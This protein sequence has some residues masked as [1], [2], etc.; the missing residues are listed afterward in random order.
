MAV[1]SIS[2]DT[3]QFSSF[4]VTA[5][6]T[7][8]L[9]DAGYAVTRARTG[10]IVFAARTEEACSAWLRDEDYDPERFAIARGP[11]MNDDAAELDRL[12]AIKLQALTLLGSASW[13]MFR[14]DWFTA[15]WAKSEAEDLA[16]LTAKDLAV[17]PLNCI[18]WKQAALHWR[19]AGYVAI[20]FDGADYYAREI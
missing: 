11:L 5:R 6:I 13:A 8:I 12:R 18:D 10:R 15:D 1:T 2:R 20:A 7:A 19:N 4:D 3:E 16:G 17:W 14:K 9:A